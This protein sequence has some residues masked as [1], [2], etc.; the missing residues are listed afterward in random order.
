MA[1]WVM[2]G[3]IRLLALAAGLGLVLAPFAAASAV[4][5]AIKVVVN[6]DPITTYDIA[7]RKRLIEITG[8][9]RGSGAEK[10]AI[11]EL[12]DERL[13]LQEA[14]RRN[15]S[16]SDAEIEDAFASLARRTKMTPAQFRAAL[17]Q[18]GVDP[19]TLMDR[20]R[21]EIAWR[22]VVQARFRATIRV[23]E[24]A[25]VAALGGKAGT[26]AAKGIEYDLKQVIF[27]IPGDAGASYKAQRRREA[28]AL[29]ARFTSCE[30]GAE[31]V[32]GLRD[33]AIKPVGLRTTS[34]LPPDRR[35][36]LAATKV[37]HLTRPQTGEFGIEMFAVCSKREI[38]SDSVERS[39]ARLQLMNEKGE[40]LARSYIRDLR[41]DAFIEYR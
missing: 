32:K 40:A 23:E 36:A 16:T 39:E 28:E 21:G 31:L 15:V 3:R 14:K 37:G 29:R 9:A 17:K 27:V 10:A 1:E 30:T 33:V 4:A 19:T 13:K 38:G 35:E 8:Q 24:S 20:L 26:A 2:A 5:A 11:D 6:S 18:V 34:E 7:Q 22:K 41:R 25:I 12:I